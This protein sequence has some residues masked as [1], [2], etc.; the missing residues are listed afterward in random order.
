M[1]SRLPM[2]CFAGKMSVAH[3]MLLVRCLHGYPYT[4]ACER[5]I[6]SVRLAQTRLLAFY[7]IAA[8][9]VQL[10]PAAVSIHVTHPVHT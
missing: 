4:A 6:Y 3:A 1:S 7:R 5:R 8:N 10:G 2:Q 9:A